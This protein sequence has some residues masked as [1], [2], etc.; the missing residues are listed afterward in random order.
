[1]S[2]NVRT[3][4]FFAILK[5]PVSQDKEKEELSDKLY[6]SSNLRIN[7]EG[8]M[9]YSIETEDDCCYGLFISKDKT[10]I[11]KKDISNFISECESNDLVISHKNISNYTCIWYNGVDSDMA[12][13]TL[14]EYKNK[15]KIK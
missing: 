12:M 1:M 9:V 13:L 2:E 11:S 10:D 15:L 4:G 14:E 3:T 8:T 5:N 6:D 7:Y